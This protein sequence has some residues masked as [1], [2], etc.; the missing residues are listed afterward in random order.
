MQDVYHYLRFPHRLIELK[1]F[2]MFPHGVSTPGIHPVNGGLIDSWPPSIRNGRK[3]RY[4]NAPLVLHVMAHGHGNQE[5]EHDQ[6]NHQ[7]GCSHKTGISG[8]CCLSACHMFTR[9]AVGQHHRKRKENLGQDAVRHGHRERKIQSDRQS[10][11]KP[12]QNNGDQAGQSKPSDP[13]TSLGEEKPDRHDEYEQTNDR[14]E[15]AMQVF[16]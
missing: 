4:C 15:Y 1:F 9:Q 5:L 11:E 16:V 7:P 8:Y 2:A 6:G 13:A 10:T 14:G 3:V 12:L